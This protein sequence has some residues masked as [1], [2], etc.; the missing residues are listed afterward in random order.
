MTQRDVD[1]HTALTAAEQ[2]FLQLCDTEEE[3]DESQIAGA[4][5]AMEAAALRAGVVVV[6][7]PLDQFS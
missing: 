3:L 4:Y 1:N 2:D 7:V 6:G 5:E